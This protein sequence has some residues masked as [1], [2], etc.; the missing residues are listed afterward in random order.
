MHVSGQGCSAHPPFIGHLTA[1]TQCTKVAAKRGTSH[2][3]LFA[4]DFWY[5]HYGLLLDLSWYAAVLVAVLWVMWAVAPDRHLLCSIVEDM[6]VYTSVHAQLW[7]LCQ[8]LPSLASSC[9]LLLAMWWSQMQLPLDLLTG[10]R[11]VHCLLWVDVDGVH[12]PVSVGV[13]C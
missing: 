3:N 2:V 13:A 9:S 6:S 5:V 1:P 12:S 7:A 8:A 11:D 4:S 10:L